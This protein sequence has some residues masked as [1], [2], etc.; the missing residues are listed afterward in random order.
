VTAQ[1][2]V[3]VGPAVLVLVVVGLAAERLWPAVR[4]PLGA[5]GHRQDAA[6]LALYALVAVPVVTLLGT[7]FAVTVFDLAPWLR[8]HSLSPVP[9][10]ALVVL[11]VFVMDACDWFGH[12][13]NHRVTMFW[14]YHALHHSQEE[15]S[16]LTSFR[17]H[18]LVHASFQIA[19]LP[20][21]LLGTAGAVP[22][23]V[24]IA[25]VLF[26]TLPHANVPWAFGPLRYVLVSPAYHRLHHARD[27]QR[28]VNLGTVFVWWDVLARLAVFPEPGAVPV[29]TGLQGRP[30]PVEQATASSGWLTLLSL[31]ARQLVEPFR[32]AARA[33]TPPLDASTPSS[34]AFARSPR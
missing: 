5:P 7:G 8:V 2:L 9:R 23:P 26:S 21:V 22:T 17:A 10:W 27:D 19:T 24:L 33:T 6:Y 31:L 14:R 15:M 4:R 30:I 16:I 18:P 29:T 3:L 1:G 12:F 28:G 11:V 32:P 20:L 25:Y 34:L 13:L